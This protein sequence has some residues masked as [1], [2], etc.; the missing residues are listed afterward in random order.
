MC[1]AYISGCD[2]TGVA[3]LNVGCPICVKFG[4]RSLHKMVLIICEFPAYV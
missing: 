4:M 3:A 2:R 1:I